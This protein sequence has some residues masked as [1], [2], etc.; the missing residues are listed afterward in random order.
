MPASGAVIWRSGK[1][2]R[3]AGLFQNEGMPP[4]VLP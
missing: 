1:P 3:S 2:R 4:L